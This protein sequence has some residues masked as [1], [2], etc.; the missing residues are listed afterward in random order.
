MDDL[1]RV[2]APGPKHAIE[3]RIDERID[4]RLADLQ[5]LHPRVIDLSL[6][7]IER[8]LAALDNPHRH[9]PPVIHIAGTNGKGSTLAFLRAGLEAAGQR[10]H[11]YTSPHLVRFNERIGLAG[12]DIDD[13]TLVDL[14]DRVEAANQGEEITY[15]EVTTAIAYLAYSEHP[16]DWLLLETGLGGRLDATNVI[17]QPAACVITPV[18]IDHQ[19][20]LGDSLAEIAAEKAGIF[21]PNVPAVIAPQDDGAL[22]VLENA[23][24]EMGTPLFVG[25]QDWQT[26]PCK[27]GFRYSGQRWALDLPLLALAGDH[28]RINAATAV[29]CFDLL[30]LCD[31]TEENVAISLGQATW[32]GRLQPVSLGSAGLPGWQYWVDGGHNGAAAAAL[33]RWS[34]DQSETVWLAVAM[35]DNR[36]LSEFLRPFV[37][38]VAGII[39]L[40]GPGDHDWHTPEAI[41]AAAMAQGIESATATTVEHAAAQAAQQSPTGRLLITGSLYLVGDVLAHCGAETT[42]SP[43]SPAASR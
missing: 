18:S 33:A 20:Y 17:D 9:L 30:D 42:A 5:R 36:T 38:A 32:P 35:L 7:R 39:A 1:G 14:I 3:E 11:T 8:L 34:M 19:S 22:A 24:A 23:A 21:K 10:V 31:V 13:V 6:G 26:E 43:A 40:P 25:G 16:A 37:G 27:Q 41:A 29:A 28:Q 12:T 2:E 15:F 4:Q